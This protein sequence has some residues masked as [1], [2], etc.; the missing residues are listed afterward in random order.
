MNNEK[1]HDSMFMDVF[2]QQR[3]SIIIFIKKGTFNSNHDVFETQNSI[4]FN[5]FNCELQ[6]FMSK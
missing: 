5:I 4:E 3:S 2:I 1:L 6:K